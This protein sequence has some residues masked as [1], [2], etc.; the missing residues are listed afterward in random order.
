MKIKFHQK[1]SINASV[2]LTI[3]MEYSRFNNE[4]NLKDYEPKK[5]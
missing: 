2:F 4:K 1:E 3:I 5:A